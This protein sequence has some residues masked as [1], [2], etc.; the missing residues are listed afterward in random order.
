MKFIWQ[1]VW[2][3]LRV[4]KR[5]LLWI[6]LVGALTSAFKAVSPELIRQLQAAWADHNTVRAYELPFVVALAWTLSSLCRFFHVS[7][8]KYVTELIVVNLRR[9]LMNKYLSL[10]L[11]FYQ[12][13]VRGSGGLISRMI[14]D[15]AIIGSG[16]HKIS[17]VMREPFMAAFA[18]GYL[19]YLDWRLTVFVLAASPLIMGVMRNLARSL[20]KYGHSNQ[21][22]MEDLTKTLKESL[23]GTRI[24]QSFNLEDE[25]R[26]RFEAQS[27]HYLATQRKIN[28]REEAAGPASEILAAITLAV[29]LIYIG[30]QILNRHLTVGDFL[31]FS[32]AVGLLQES[33]KK[34]QD[35]YIRIQ[36]AAVALQR[37]HAILDNTSTVPQVANPKAFPTDWQKIEF[38]NVSFKFDKELILKNI[39]LTIRRGE[40]V[41][42]VG[43]SGGGKSTLVNLLPRFFDPS[44]GEIL[45]DDIPIREIDLHDLRSHIALVSQDVFLFADSIARNIHAGDFAKDAMGVR[46]AAGL[47]NAD[48]F[49]AKTAH[50]YQSHVGDMGSTLSG[51]EKQ[52]ISIARAIFKDAPILI[53]D[54][55][56][57]ALDSESEREVQKGLDQLM[58]GRTAFVIA[59]RL[60]TIAKANRILV[61][62]KGEIIEEGSHQ[63]L[64]T[65]DGTYAKFLTLQQTGP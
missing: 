19:I 48:N 38:R 5:Q 39:D 44:D 8:M 16:I 9:Q 42:I 51:G 31:G 35:G 1:K 55:A 64:L 36:Q 25:I 17:D 13:F 4:H 12:S 2:P 24:V 33:I 53:L 29:L 43:A 28:V 49:I 57:S 56:T 45:V 30:N 54:E 6:L 20:R 37:L 32:F 61:I 14:N 63:E 10:N 22:T 41:A 26:R 23:D 18:F 65:V 3:E 21:E 59:H 46:E 47:A 50:G 62:R 11:S 27:K 15:I 40:L 60:S 58:E 34:L 7:W 52:R